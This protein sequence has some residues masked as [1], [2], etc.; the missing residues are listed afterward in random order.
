MIRGRISR[1]EWWTFIQA[2]NKK[3]S[4]VNQDVIWQD[5]FEIEHLDKELLRLV[6]SVKPYVT[7]AVLSNCGPISKERIVRELDEFQAFD[8]IFSS[9]D[10]NSA[11][12]EP[13][14][15][16]AVTNHLQLIP[17]DILYFDDSEKNV[18]AA[19]KLGINSFLYQ[20]ADQV[21]SLLMK[22]GWIS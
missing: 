8:F 18:E 17:S 1:E 13:E 15:F 19:A 11:K 10:F 5:L 6:K 16:H 22:L 12:P 14:I 7:T 21:E 20:G 2:S 9:S 4:L 3:L